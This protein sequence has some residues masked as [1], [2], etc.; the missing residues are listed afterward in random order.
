[1]E[2][3]GVTK[4]VVE[5]LRDRIITGELQAGQKLNETDLSSLLGISRPPLRE[6]FRILEEGDLVVS[7]PRRGCYVADVSLEEFEQLYQ[8]REMTE[9]YVIDLLKEKKKKEFHEIKKALSEAAQVSFPSPDNPKE[10]LEY[11]SKFANFHRQL[12]KTCEN[13]KIIGFYEK[14]NLNISRYQFMYAY[15]PGL[16]SDSQADHEHVL[17][18]I[19]DGEYAEAK[20]H[21]RTHIKSFVKLM[22]ARMDGKIEPSK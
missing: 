12:V 4:A 11:L 2:I 20:K 17:E 22:K 21:L 19:E 13:I 15:L 5:Y 3:L 1:M 16:T 14:L 18:L 9:C 10:H 6:A 8:A 7:V